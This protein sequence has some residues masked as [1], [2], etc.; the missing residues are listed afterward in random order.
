MLK[1]KNTL[2]AFIFVGLFWSLSFAS[3]EYTGLEATLDVAPKLIQRDTATT[4]NVTFRGDV[5]DLQ[6]L[7]NY[8]SGQDLVASVFSPLENG[9]DAGFKSNIFPSPVKISSLINGQQISWSF[10]QDYT[11]STGVNYRVFQGKVVCGGKEVARSGTV[12]VSILANSGPQNSPIGTTKTYDFSVPN[13]LAGGPDSVVGLLSIVIRWLMNIAI[14]IAVAMIIYGG[15]LFLT[16]GGNPGNVKKGRMVIT[17]AVIGL[18]IIFIGRGFITLIQSIL[19]LGGTSGVGVETKYSCTD[20]GFCVADPNGQFSNPSCDSRCSVSGPTGFIGSLCSKDSN[21]NTGLKCANTVC[22]RLTG[23][24]EGEFC[25]AGSDCDIGL[26]CDESG[27]NKVTVDGRTLGTC[28]KTSVT[29]SSIGD[30]CSKNSDCISGL[31]CNQICQRRG[32]NA[33]GEICLKTS[34]PSNCD[35]NACKTSGTEIVGICVSQ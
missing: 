16:A 6:I 2:A 13:P 35:S 32:G 31:E 21:C 20:K 14:P 19:K 26:F 17:Y 3:G 9:Q 25:N 1:S 5:R 29:G 11:H 30:A 8:C 4:L 10:Q 27:A 24:K 15:I 23:N 7:S 22:Q 28:F 33:N 34:N 18:A 12:Q